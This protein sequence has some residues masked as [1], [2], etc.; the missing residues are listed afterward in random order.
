M[1]VIPS[2]T[3]NNGVPIPQL[4]LGAYFMPTE[5]TEKAVTSALELGYRLIDTAAA[6]NNEEEVGLGIR[7]SG[8]PREEIFVTTK[9][10]NNFHG[11]QNTL[12]AFDTSLKKLSLDYLYLFLFHWPCPQKG[13]VGETWKAFEELYQLGRVKAI[14]VCNFNSSH[15]G[16]LLK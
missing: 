6:Y 8:V 4:G 2:L 7:N 11:Y 16:R 15:L 12:K 5:E 9:L 3:L 1:L 10:W 14:G 13:L